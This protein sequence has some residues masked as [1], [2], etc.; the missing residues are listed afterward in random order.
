MPLSEDLTGL[1]VRKT[2]IKTKVTVK[3]SLKIKEL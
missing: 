3:P 2:I 1:L